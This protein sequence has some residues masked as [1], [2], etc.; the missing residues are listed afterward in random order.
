M[1]MLD[2]DTCSYILR[3]HPSGARARFNRAAPGEIALSTVVLAELFFG[4]DRLPGRSYLRED[5]QRFADGV[6]VLAWDAAAADHYGRIRAHLEQ[7]GKPIGA[8]DM[9]IGA[10]AKSVDAILVTNNL[11]HFRRV[12]GLKLENWSLG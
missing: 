10:H 12:P 11:E 7:R 2:T 3:A 9:M 5:I 8:M 4:A 6:A 1:W